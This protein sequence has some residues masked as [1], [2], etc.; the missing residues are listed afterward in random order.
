MYKY[1][2]YGLALPVSKANPL[3]GFEFQSKV[4]QIPSYTMI[5]NIHG[6]NNDQYG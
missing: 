2:P 5:V 1:K 3:G 6:D 4:M